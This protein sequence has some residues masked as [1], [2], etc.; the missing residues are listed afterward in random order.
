MGTSRSATAF[1]P[2]DQNSDHSAASL[3]GG[4]SESLLLEVLEADSAE[5]PRPGSELRRCPVCAGFTIIH[6]LPFCPFG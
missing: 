6:V 3:V 1:H 2:E 5:P 4:A